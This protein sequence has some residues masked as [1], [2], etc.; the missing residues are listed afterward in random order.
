MLDLIQ[1][2]PEIIVAGTALILLILDLIF[3]PKKYLV[4]ILSIAGLLCSAVAILALKSNLEIFSHTFSSDPLTALF[5]LVFLSLGV[6]ILLLLFE[7][8]KI[9]NNDIIPIILFAVSGMMLLAGST[10]LIMLYVSLELISIS[11]YI[12]ASF[13]KSDNKSTEAGI[14]YLILGA[15]ASAVFLY[16]LSLIYGLTGSTNLSYA[17]FMMLYSKV[18]VLNV[19]ATILVITGLGFKIALVPFHMWTPDVYEGAPTPITALFSVGPK[20]AAFVLLIRIMLTGLLITRPSWMIILAFVAVATMTL[21]NLAAIPQKNI[22]RMMAYSSIAQAGYIILGLVASTSSFGIRGLFIYLAIYLFTNIGAF[23]CILAVENKLNTLEI[24]NYGGLAQKAPFLSAC[25]A[26]FFLSLVGIPPFGGFIAKFF[27][28]AGLI[29]AGWIWLAIIGVVNS[30]ISL[31]YYFN[32]V[33]EMYFVKPIHDAPIKNI[34]S[35][36]F[37]ILA[38]LAATIILGIFPLPLIKMAN[39]A[40]GVFLHF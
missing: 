6:F 12:M 27:I 34:W 16:G 8:D 21:G 13:L 19:L 1:I 18:N 36:N 35:T 14:K 22:K 17:G 26:M 39:M 28:F 20:A 29:E 9:K 23:A 32:V 2:L 10:D 33:R 31:Y 40:L 24:E 7:Y 11:S 25:L 5:R 38:T 4:L 37:V 30:V 15:L 3:R